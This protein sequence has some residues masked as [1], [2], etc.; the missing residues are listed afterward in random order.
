MWL[1]LAGVIGAAISVQGA[2]NDSSHIM[3]WI[4]K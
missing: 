1:R 4:S 2:K 3:K